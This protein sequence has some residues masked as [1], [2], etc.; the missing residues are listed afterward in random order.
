MMKCI[1]CSNQ[2]SKYWFN[3]KDK[4]LCEQCYEDEVV[5]HISRLSTSSIPQSLKRLTEIL[6]NNVTFLEWAELAKHF[7][8]PYPATLEDKYNL[9]YRMLG[10]CRR[11]QE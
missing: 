8:K 9:T 2:S 11:E 3:I 7:G 4:T 1:L 6:V 10:Y 5:N